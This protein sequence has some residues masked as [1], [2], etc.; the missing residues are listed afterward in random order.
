M[1]A[2]PRDELEE[3]MRRWVTAND[4]AGQTGDWDP[5]GDFYTDDSIYTWNN[6]SVK[7]RNSNSRS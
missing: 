4:R 3:M 5:M 7:P 2:F 6:G 1:P